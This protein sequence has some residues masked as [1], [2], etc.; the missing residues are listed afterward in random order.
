MYFYSRNVLPIVVFLFILITI[1]EPVHAQQGAA[2]TVVAA[3]GDIACDPAN[4]NIN[5]VNGIP[6]GKG[7]NC[8]MKYTADLI[9]QINPNT[10]LGLGDMQYEDGVFGKY[11]TS[12]GPSGWGALK[13]KTYVTSGGGHDQNGM[14]DF[15][16]YWGTH[17]GPSITQTWF[18]FE[19]GSWHITELNM[20]C[21]AVDCAKELAWFKT[22][23]AAHPT[24]CS[25]AFWHFPHWGSG[26]RGS[27]TIPEDVN[28]RNYSVPFIQAFYDAGGELILNGHDHDYERFAPQNPSG[29]LDNTR[30]VREIVVGTGGDSI[31]SF[32]A[33]VANREA[34]NTDTIGIL[35]LT[36]NQTS[37]N[38]DFIPASFS[39]N[40]TF[41]DSGTTACHTSNGSLPTISPSPSPSQEITRF[42]TTVLLHGIGKGGD[43][44]N[45][46]GLGNN[47]PL[48]P[49]LQIEAQVFDKNNVLVTTKQGILLYNATT[50]S[51][52]GNIDGGP[53]PS[54]VYTLKIKAS[55]YLQKMIPGIIFTTSGTQ[56][57][58][59]SVSLINGDSNN[60]NALSILD[61][62][63]L[64]DCFSDLSPAKNCADSNKKL[65][66]DLTD[67]GNVNQFDY[68]L[69]LRELSVQTGE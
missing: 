68:N 44:S 36:L 21:D 19:V 12:F 14:G 67:D 13:G 6:L 25:L 18:S 4:P 26:L 64:L 51:F 33:T 15:Y 10:V 46:T 48:H 28:R 24:T 66:T 3:A 39:G 11:D 49:Q 31:N 53:L 47:N 59:P 38:W 9:N 22:D 55:H 69:F 58:L 60:D 40:G 52:S 30:G 8:R 35:K 45:P 23:L 32:I 27:G 50:G 29:A 65:M 2:G 7:L 37:Y 56:T 16:T 63:M 61:Y 54:S 17:A 62:N 42:L 1:T 5:I 41:R 20:N 57:T 43:N 34:G